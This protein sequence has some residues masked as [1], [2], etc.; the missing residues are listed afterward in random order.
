MADP[1]V[2]GVDFGSKPTRDLAA[3]M[4]FYGET[5]GLPRSAHR[6]GYFAE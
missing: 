5:L 1:I 6:D 3:S 4:T 2:T